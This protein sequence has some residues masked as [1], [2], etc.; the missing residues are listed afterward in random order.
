MSRSPPSS[1]DRRDAAEA[2]VEQVRRTLA[3]RNRSADR[4]EE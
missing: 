1:D 4:N 2:A 3:V